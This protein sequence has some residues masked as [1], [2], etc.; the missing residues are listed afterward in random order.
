MQ[1][2][3][4]LVRPITQN[5]SATHAAYSWSPDGSKAVFQ[6][7]QL[8]ASDNLPEIILWDF[9][10]GEQQVLVVDGALPQWMP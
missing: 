9:S 5:P 6:R 7:F 8:G 1:P 3:G 4:D 2:D 10:S